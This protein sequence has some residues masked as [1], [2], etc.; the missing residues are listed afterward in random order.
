VAPSAA[1]SSSAS[2]YAPTTATPVPCPL[3]SVGA[4]AASPTS[5]TRPV[6]QLGRWIWVTSSKKK[7]FEK[8]MACSSCGMC[9]AVDVLRPPSI[10]CICGERSARFGFLRWALQTA[11]PPRVAAPGPHRT[12]LAMAPGT[13]HIHVRLSVSVTFGPRRG[14]CSSPSVCRT[15]LRDRSQRPDVGVQPV[16]SCNQ[17]EPLRGGVSEV[18]ED[19]V[20]FFRGFADAVTPQV[21][22]VLVDGA[23]TSVRSSRRIS[24]SPSASESATSVIGTL[25]EVSSGSGPVRS[26]TVTAALRRSMAN[27]PLR[28]AV[29]FSTTVTSQPCRFSQNATVSPA[30]VAPDTKTRRFGTGADVRTASAVAPT[31]AGAPSW[32][33]G[34]SGH[35]VG[36]S[37]ARAVSKI[38]RR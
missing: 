1:E 22:D 12:R 33:S 29:H 26:V 31:G 19:A 2:T 9:Q 18:N 6:L 24:R 13:V 23:R 3:I 37:P 35:G 20:G 15:V 38:G 4:W 10:S 27:P 8:H 17:V 21:G 28:G 5:T 25:R 14:L 34:G 11:K 36:R 30:A 32:G 16:S 7:S